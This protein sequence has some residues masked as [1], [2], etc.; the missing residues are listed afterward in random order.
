MP[1]T[2]ITQAGPEHLNAISMLVAG[3]TQAQTAKQLGINRTTLARWIQKPW[4]QAAMSKA[5]I[6]V[7]E[8]LVKSILSRASAAYQVLTEIM[9]DPT[10]TPREKIA[11]AKE[12]RQ[13]VAPL[14]GSVQTLRLETDPADIPFDDLALLV[15]MARDNGAES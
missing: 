1:A 15:K 5:Q 3:Y 10:S 7:R 2:K 9:L 14:L 11:C 8:D 4:F 6:E 12:I 13:G